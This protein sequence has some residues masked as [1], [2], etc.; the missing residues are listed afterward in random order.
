MSVR[1]YGDRVTVQAPLTTPPSRGSGPVA[2]VV[3][4]AGVAAVLAIAGAGV[5]FLSEYVSSRQSDTGPLGSPGGEASPAKVPLISTA[6]FDTFREDLRKETGTTEVVHLTIYPLYAV[7]ELVTD[8]A[9]GRTKSLYYDGA[10]SDSGLGTTTDRP[11][12]VAEID[13]DKMVSLSRKVRK[14]VDDPNQWY[15]V[16][17]GPDPQGGVIYAYAS[18]AYGEGAYISATPAGK[19]VSRVTW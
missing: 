13:A 8:P 14:M 18:N 11:F 4:L 7:V 1:R 17:S 15:L 5:Y 16:M 10:F 3:L 6:G 2:V 19:V 9:K 12:D